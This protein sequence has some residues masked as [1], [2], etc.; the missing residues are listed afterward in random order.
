[1]ET[2]AGVVFYNP[3]IER[4]KKNITAVAPQVDEVVVDNSSSNIK[5]VQQL[6]CLYDNVTVPNNKRNMGIAKAL[7][8]LFEYARIHSYEWVLTLD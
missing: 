1:M 7:N 4:L 5:D 6:L 3:D 8:Q 2:V